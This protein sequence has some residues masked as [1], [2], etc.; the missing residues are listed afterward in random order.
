MSKLLKNAH[1]IYKK[2]IDA[3]FELPGAASL[4][5]WD[6]AVNEK[7][8]VWA[9]KAVNKVNEKAPV[10]DHI[11]N[12]AV[13]E[14]KQYEDYIKFYT[15]QGYIFDE[16][17]NITYNPFEDETNPKYGTS[18]ILHPTDM[19]SIY[20]EEDIQNRL[21][22]QAQKDQILSSSAER[23]NTFDETVSPS[24]LVNTAQTSDNQSDTGS[25]A[26]KT[27][28]SN[29]NTSSK[30]IQSIIPKTSTVSTPEISSVTGTAAYEYTTGAPTNSW[31]EIP[32]TTAASMEQS[33][34]SVLQKACEYGDQ[35][36]CQQLSEQ[37]S[38]ADGG[39]VMNTPTPT[40]NKS[41]GN[42]FG[43]AS[44]PVQGFSG[45]GSVAP[46]PPM[47]QP[48]MPSG[49]SMPMPPMGEQGGGGD[50]PPMAPTGA[51]MGMEGG[52]GDMDSLLTK[53][54]EDGADIGGTGMDVIM[55]NVG[56]MLEE[57]EVMELE[58]AFSTYPVLEKV[59][60]M[61][62]LDWE[63]Q[64]EGEGGPTSDDIPAR[65]SDGEFVFTAKAVEQIGVD[66]LQKMM[67]DAEAKADGMPENPDMNFK[68]GGLVKRKH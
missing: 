4:T 29:T 20:T 32:S 7:A 67:E 41:M 52:E 66:K 54:M 3:S 64:V 44:R 27:G 62:P 61:L 19:A 10:S 23:R 46:M 28:S 21:A 31:N 24:L 43:A 2:G 35:A 25:S 33:G 50:M 34:Y 45:G 47:G 14:E 17:G 22:N 42:K 18:P 26:S 51:S 40:P 6:R 1:G 8:G 58:E 48:P 59:V 36:A 11:W 55:T 56:D 49:G 15:E 13:K 63:G 12:K 9:K 53:G 37:N 60:G 16:K 65:L 68:C 39:L 30:S 38:Y 5:P 57:N